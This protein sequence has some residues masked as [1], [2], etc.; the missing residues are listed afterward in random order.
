M[1]TASESPTHGTESEV[2]SC[3]GVAP[4]LP[5][6]APRITRVA[7]NCPRLT[8]NPFQSIPPIPRRTAFPPSFGSCCITIPVHPISTNTAGGQN[9]EVGMITA[10]ESRTHGIDVWTGSGSGIE[11]GSKKGCQWGWPACAWLGVLGSGAFP[12]YA[13]VLFR[14]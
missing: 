1:I 13:Q 3:V 6:R 5:G 11:M 10:S 7:A 12:W 2:L 9:R 4:W 14:V 8:H